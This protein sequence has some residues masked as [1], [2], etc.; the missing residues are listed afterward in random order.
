MT[1]IK[2]KLA[3]IIVL[4]CGIFLIISFNQSKG[5]YK[6][7]QMIYG[8]VAGDIKDV[9]QKCSFGLIDTKTG[10]ITE[11]I[12]DFGSD[13]SYPD[14]TL[15]PT[16]QYVAFNKWIEKTD[17]ELFIYDLKNK[18]SKQLTS[19]SNGEINRISWLDDST[20]IGVFCSHEKGK[21][22]WHL[23]SFDIKTNEMK[24]LTNA[25]SQN[26]EYVYFNGVK[27]LTGQNKIL[28]ARG[29]ESEYLTSW[30]DKKYKNALYIC[31]SQG[32]NI[33]KLL[34]FDDRTIGGISVSHDNENVL[35]EAFKYPENNNE[36]EC[37]DLYLY[38]LKTGET[39]LLEDG[40]KNAQ[41]EH[42]NLNWLDNNSVVYRNQSE[43]KSIDINTMKTS[44][45]FENN[46]N[47]VAV[48]PK[49]K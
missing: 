32:L 18:T 14:A 39:K 9:N 41:I 37:S 2:N 16:G 20:I 22:G 40:T 11:K 25:N 29:N 12:F 47:L 27:A 19:N 23:F 49:V 34:T 7:E 1:R 6:D 15:S 24:F 33:E 48:I 36:L 38:N 4:L 45:L 43:W 8:I 30:N 5:I 3:L 10:D 28:F 42:W 26:G 46:K 17:R 13:G 21:D 31:D 44:S 35:I